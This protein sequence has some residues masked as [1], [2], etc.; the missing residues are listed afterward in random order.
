V[1]A[2]PE[3]WNIIPDTDFLDTVS[4]A[5]QDVTM[6]TAFPDSRIIFAKTDLLCGGVHFIYLPL[7]VR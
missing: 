2:S 4:A 1:D 5:P 3:K 6:A 7:V